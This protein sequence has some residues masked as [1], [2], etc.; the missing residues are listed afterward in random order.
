MANQV[1]NA[2]DDLTGE[3]LSVPVECEEH[4][5]PEGRLIGADEIPEAG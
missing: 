3:L 4:R 2:N 5:G 1:S